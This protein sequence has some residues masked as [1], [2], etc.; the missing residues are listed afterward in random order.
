M[1]VKDGLVKH[2]EK[3][4]RPERGQ[5]MERRNA[6]AAQQHITSSLLTD[7]RGVTMLR[8]RVLPNSLL[9]SLFTDGES[10]SVQHL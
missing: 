7:A 6:E 5:E 10:Q 2:E 9:F 3:P 4:M 1:M 8:T